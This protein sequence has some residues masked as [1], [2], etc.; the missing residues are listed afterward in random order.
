[1]ACC[2]EMSRSKKL[3]TEDWCIKEP[4]CT[5]RKKKFQLVVKFFQKNIKKECIASVPACH[6]FIFR[7]K[8]TVAKPSPIDFH[9]KLHD[10]N[11]TKKFRKLFP[12]K[13]FKIFFILLVV[14]QL[15]IMWWGTMMQNFSETKKLFFS[16]K[17]L[18]KILS[19]CYFSFKLYSS[20]VFSVLTFI[21][22]HR[23]K[24]GKI[25]NFFWFSFCFKFG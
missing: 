17:K 20:K 7:S 23:M 1:M 24:I 8:F 16:Q 6:A 14:N 18:A 9:R 10:K 19:P 3:V 12:K 21:Q 11:W 22:N 15:S 2:D 4:G 13:I 25:R 5:L